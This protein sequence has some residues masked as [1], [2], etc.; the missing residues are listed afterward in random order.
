MLWLKYGAYQET[1]TPQ[2]L[3]YTNTCHQ[4]LI[5]GLGVKEVDEAKSKKKRK[6]RREWGVQRLEEKEK[7]PDREG[8]TGE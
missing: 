6:R 7:G 5:I 3:R 8:Q 2:S 1:S 4:R